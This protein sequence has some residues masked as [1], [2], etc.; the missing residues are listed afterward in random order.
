MRRVL[1]LYH[2][3]GTMFKV[4]TVP[5]MRTKNQLVLL[6]LKSEIFRYY[7]DRDF[8][9]IGTRGVRVGRSNIISP[10]RAS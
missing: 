4:V 5:L 10:P 1:L 3:L 2:R 7:I 8:S 6:Y 9:C